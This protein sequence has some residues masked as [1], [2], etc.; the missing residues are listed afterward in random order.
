M[1]YKLL[2]S[3]I[4]LFIFTGCI[5][6][7]SPSVVENVQGMKPIY[8]TPDDATKIVS[9]SP[10]EIQ[11]LGKIYYKSP[12][13]YA[14]EKNRG[15]HIINNTD[16]KAPQKVSFIKVAGIGDMAIKGNYMYVDN[17]SDLVTLNIGDIDNIKEVSRIEDAYTDGQDH[18]PLGYVGYF[19][20]PDPEKGLVV[21]WIEGLIAKPD[22]YTR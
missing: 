20:C 19:E 11:Y 3:V 12:Y 6:D 1:T 21:G 8:V 15:I 18:A 13:I 7:W 14:I 5:D 9:G 4:T 10:Q 17:M 22:C 16:P 2:F